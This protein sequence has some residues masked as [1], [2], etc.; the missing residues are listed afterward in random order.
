MTTILLIDDQAEY[1][2]NVVQMLN[3]EGFEV[4]VGKGGSEGVL[5][6]KHHH[7]DLILCDMLMP[8]L[9]GHEVQ[10]LLQEDEATAHI[11]LVFLTG[12]VDKTTPGSNRSLM[13]PFTIADLLHIIHEVVG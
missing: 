5:L 3:F 8:G 2:A 7:P 6:A 12:S 13:K 9:D 11:P 1:L 4:L 10:R